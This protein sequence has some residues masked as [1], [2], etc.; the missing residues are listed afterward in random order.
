MKLQCQQVTMPDAHG[1]FK[2]VDAAIASGDAEID[3]Q[4]VRHVDSSVLALLLHAQ[5]SLSARQK[6]LR[7][8]HAPDALKRLAAAYGIEILFDHSLV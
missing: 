3:L 1:A 2:A 8:I 6:T 7:V 5:R 4:A